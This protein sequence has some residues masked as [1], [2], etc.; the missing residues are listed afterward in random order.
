MPKSRRLHSIS[1]YHRRSEFTILVLATNWTGSPT[2]LSNGANVNMAQTTNGTLLFAWLNTSKQNNAGVLS[3]TSGGGVPQTYPAPALVNQPSVLLNNWQGNNLSVTNITTGPATPI[4]IAAYGP[5]L[6]GNYPV[7]LPSDGSTVSLGV[8]A[9]AAGTALPK[10]M[11]L[12]MSCTSGTLALVAI[13]GGPP[14]KSGN[15]GYAIALNAATDSGPDGPTPPAGYYATTTGNTYRFQFYWGSASIF[16]AVMSPFTTPTVD[17][18]LI[19][20]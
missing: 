14:D 3:L 8:L 11:Q 10:Y 13:I 2:T 17:V 16:V 5:N 20:L 12:T 1:T 7:N 4:W 18:A 6:P 15:N 9:T 19:A